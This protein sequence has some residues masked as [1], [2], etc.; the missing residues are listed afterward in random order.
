MNVALVQNPPAKTPLY[1]WH[2]AHHCRMVDFAGWSMPVQYESIVAEHQAVRSGVGLF[3]VSHM[4][5]LKFTGPAALEFLDGLL[6]R[7]VADLAEGQVRYSLMTSESGG[8]LDDVLIYRLADEA[9]RDYC[10]LVV[11]A[12][13]RRKI[14]DW[15]SAHLAGHDVHATDLT[16]ETCLIAVQGPTAARALQPLTDLDLAALKYYHAAPTAV[17]GRPAI[18]SRTGYT[19][20]DG[21]EVMAAADAA[22][23][24]WE[25]ILESGRGDGAVPA[26][27]G[28]RDT[29]RLEAAMPLYGHELSET[30]DPLTAGLAFAVNLEGRKFPG[31]DALARIKQRPLE[32]RRVGLE[33][34]GRRVPREH[35]AIRRANEPISS[36][37]IGEVTSGTFSPTLGRPIAMGYVRADSA[38]PGTDLMVD[39]RGQWEPARIVK[40]PFYRRK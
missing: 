34:A 7:R 20:E 18:V 27:L 17:G 29:L 32:R 8:I 6:T 22:V 16:I 9:G 36:E 33:L 39:I 11:N 2:A 38:E 13:N 3:D 31:R 5:R 21:F 30:I 24:I 26:G 1:D 37:S 12:S 10:L 35:Y 40:L 14:W 4:G 15:V 23:E 28:A 25:A 19:G